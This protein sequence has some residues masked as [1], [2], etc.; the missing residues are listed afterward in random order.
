MFWVVLRSKYPLTVTAL[1]VDLL[2]AV[3]CLSAAVC[4]AS[5][6]EKH[7]GEQSVQAR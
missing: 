2:L 3:I 7:R 4:I 6:V 1:A 5:V